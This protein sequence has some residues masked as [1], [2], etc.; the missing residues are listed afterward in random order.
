VS[1]KEAAER[2]RVGKKEEEEK[3]GIARDRKGS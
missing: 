3:K 1:E 2:K